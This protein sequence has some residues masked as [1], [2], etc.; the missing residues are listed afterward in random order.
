MEIRVY[1]KGLEFLG[2]IENHTSLIWTR[3]YFG[4]GSFELH[5]PLTDDNLKLIHEG[6][7]VWKR[8]CVEAGVIEDI[9]IEDSY[10]AKKITVKGRFLSSYM[11]RKV[12]KGTFTYSGTVEGAMRELL[13]NNPIPM[14]ELGE[15]SGFTD[16]VSFQTT[17]KN[18]L[19]YEQKLSQNSA[20]GF[21]FRPDFNKKK[22]FFEVYKGI[23]R[24]TS[25]RESNRVVFSESYDNLNNAI[26]RYNEQ[27]YKNVA[28]VGGEGE[29]SARKI[30]VVGDTTAGDVREIFVDAK[31]I[32]SEGL[33][34]AE[35][36]ALLRTRGEEA[37][38]SNN[39]KSSF[40]CDTGFDVN[41]TYKVHYDLGDIITVKKKKWGITVDKRITEI[42]EIYENGGMRIE[43]TFGDAMPDTIDWSDK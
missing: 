33:T 25:Q 31:D 30:V 41:F 17:Y 16:P 36:E 13:A 38:A 5:A 18:L 15:V 6:N 14:V 7:I 9:S 12:I 35:Y 24:S 10:N 42:R 34:D 19:T 2:V 20:L 21:R 26:Y 40:E 27:T 43:P 1:N 23:D 8:G 28:Y 39:I 3:K 32:Q 37:L 29:G 22:I 4:S 11:D